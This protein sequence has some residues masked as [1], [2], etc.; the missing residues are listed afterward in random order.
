MIHVTGVCTVVVSNSDARSERGI[1][2]FK[3]VLSRTLTDQE[4]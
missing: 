4:G 1:M 3:G 2:D